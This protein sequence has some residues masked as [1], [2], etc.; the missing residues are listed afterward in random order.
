M[1]SNGEGTS[2][3]EGTSKRD[4]TEPTKLKKIYSLRDVVKQVYR[5]LVEAEI[6]YRP[7]DPEYIG[8]YQRAVT[9]VIQNMAKRDIEEAE[10]IVESWN[11][12]G[13]PLAVQRK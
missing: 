8:S 3:V 2:N 10:K 5:D 13:P 7:T 6:P 12:R 4:D 9:T 11:K 1:A